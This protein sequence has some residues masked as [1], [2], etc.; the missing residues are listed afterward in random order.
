MQNHEVHFLSLLGVQVDCQVLKWTFEKHHSVDGTGVMYLDKL[1]QRKQNI[2]S[3]FR[4]PAHLE[5]SRRAVGPTLTINLL[6]N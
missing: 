1:T 3:T 5:A 2:L 4:V 6:K